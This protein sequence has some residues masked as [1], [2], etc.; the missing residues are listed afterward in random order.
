MTCLATLVSGHSLL[1]SL[2]LNW[3]STTLLCR[4]LCWTGWQ[5]WSVPWTHCC[6]HRWAS[7]QQPACCR[8][9]KGASVLQLC[10]HG[11]TNKQ[12]CT[13]LDMYHVEMALET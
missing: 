10:L 9:P 6:A 11:S 13:M 1:T 5:P 3:L 4:A 12:T 2:L 8:Q 7:L